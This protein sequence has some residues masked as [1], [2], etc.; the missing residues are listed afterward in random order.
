MSKYSKN[1][2]LSEKE[3]YELIEAELS[4]VEEFCD[5][6]TNEILTFEDL[7]RDDGI[8][9]ALIYC[10][11]MG[12]KVGRPSSTDNSP[13][14]SPPPG[15]KWCQEYGPIREVR[16]D[17][18]GHFPDFD[19]KPTHSQTRCKL[20]K[21]AGKHTFFALNVKNGYTPLLYSCMQNSGNERPS[22]PGDSTTSDQ[23]SGRKKDGVEGAKNPRVKLGYHRRQPMHIASYNVRTMSS[24]SKLL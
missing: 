18:I 17:G 4:D 7:Q 6:E 8:I 14:S 12:K 3:L 24:E 2:P 13:S 20:P 23:G 22:V 1:K 10:G 19:D 11:Q 15:K 16:L 5:E 21:C 9:E